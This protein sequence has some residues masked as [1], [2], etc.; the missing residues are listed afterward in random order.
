MTGAFDTEKLLGARPPSETLALS[1]REFEMLP[2]Q[3][4]ALSGNLRI[5]GVLLPSQEPASHAEGGDA[6]A[7]RAGEGIEDELAVV[8]KEASTRFV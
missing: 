8:R 6:G 4:Q 7:P 5:A 2:S 1:E 3:G